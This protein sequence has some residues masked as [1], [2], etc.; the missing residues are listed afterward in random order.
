MAVSI[1][2]C[3]DC[4]STLKSKQALAAGTKIKCPKCQTVFAI[5]ER[6]GAADTD[7]EEEAPP[8]RRPVAAGKELAKKAGPKPPPLRPRKEEFA[9]Y[10]DGDDEAE[11]VRPKKMKKKLKGKKKPLPINPALIAGIAGLVLLLV[12]G[13]VA[14]WVWPGFLY[15]PG[16]EPLAYVP[17]NSATVFTVNLEVLADQLGNSFYDGFMAAAPI[18]PLGF[19]ASTFKNDTGL[20]LKDMFQQ[21]TVATTE[22]FNPEDNSSGRQKAVMILKSKVPF[23]RK[24]IIA[25]LKLADSAQRLKWKTYYKRTVGSETMSVYIP[26]ERLIIWSALPEKEWGEVLTSKGHKPVPTGDLKTMID[27]VSANPVWGATIMDAAFKKRLEGLAGFIPVAGASLKEAI[28]AGKSAATWVAI[29]DGQVKFKVG[30]MCADGEAAKKVSKSLE[31]VWKL[32][33]LAFKGQVTQQI[34]QL[35]PPIQPV[36]RE[37]LDGVRFTA[38]DNLAQVSIQLNLRTV[39]AVSEEMQKLGGGGL[40]GAGTVPGGPGGFNPGGPPPGGPPR[41][42]GRPR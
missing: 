19:S 18:A 36:A 7:D 12:M 37:L 10:D 30:M 6:N 28:N 22:P 34:E 5:P 15:Q 27:T 29:E 16:S 2:A 1:F 39:K 9:E 33:L 38:Q 8:P 26:S 35:P 32:A 25:H 31:G 21:V 42:R 20:E 23:D 11:E 41:G 13:Y 24:K 17:A 14:G 4:G 3:P 40:L